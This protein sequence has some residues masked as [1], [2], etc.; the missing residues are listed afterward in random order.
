[1]ELFDEQAWPTSVADRYR[2]AQS[3]AAQLAAMGCTERLDF[4]ARLAAVVLRRRD[5]IVDRLVAATGQ[6]AGD[7]LIEE[8]SLALELLAYLTRHGRRALAGRRWGGLKRVRYQPLGVVLVLAHWHAPFYRALSSLAFAF[9][10]GNA[11]L[12]KPSP[13][14]LLPGLLESL[15]TESG[16]D[17]DWV[18][19]VPGDEAVG[20]RLLAGRPDKVL[21][22][23]SAS[24]ARAVLAQAVEGAVPVEVTPLGKVPMLVFAD[25]DLDAAVAVAVRG[26][27]AKSGQS[28]C[29]IERIY[30][31]RAVYAEFRS[32]LVMACHGLR[33]GTGRDDDMGHLSQPHRIQTVREL[34]KDALAKGARQLCGHTWDG[35]SPF[36][37][38]IVLEDCRNGV[39]LLDEPVL[40]PL[41]PLFVFDHEDEAV[42]AVSR[43]PTG[44]TALVWCRDRSRAARVAA[45]LPVNH[46]AINAP[47]RVDWRRCVTGRRR[48]EVWLRSLC[49]L[50]TWDARAELPP[51]VARYPLSSGKYALHELLAATNVR[52]GAAALLGYA[53]AK[54]QL[55]RLHDDQRR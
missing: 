36:V 45:R 35:H 22:C 30:I 41:L 21:F 40:A 31:E 14:A 27:F 51:A 52:R 11:V 48:C 32:R 17:P 1:M 38:P 28:G 15:L 34:L 25:A 19:I 20:Q 42:E 7:A 33:L 39:W 8:V 2:R 18:Q 46:V 16:F 44:P 50:Q 13:H 54:F 26:A 3:A 53:R 55:R 5:E 24:S 10:A 23:G 43:Y 47:A 12:Y 29:A 37:P 4:L 49:R 9:A 6:C